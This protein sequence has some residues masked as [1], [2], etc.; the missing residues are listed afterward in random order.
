MPV[1]LVNDRNPLGHCVHLRLQ[2]VVGSMDKP[3]GN[4]QTIDFLLILDIKK[5][6]K[7]FAAFHIL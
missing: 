7:T 6:K 5:D 3:H 4:P 1:G 2:L